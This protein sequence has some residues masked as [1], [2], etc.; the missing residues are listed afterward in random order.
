VNVVA[1]EENVAGRVGAF[2]LG[3]ARIIT[4]Q[5]DASIFHI[6]SNHTESATEDE[7]G[8]GEREGDEAQIHIQVQER[9]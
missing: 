2:L 9:E 3:C 4:I 8:E 7:S 5:R 1:E 6:E